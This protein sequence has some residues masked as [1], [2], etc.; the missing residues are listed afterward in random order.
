TWTS[1]VSAIFGGYTSMVIDHNN[2]AILYAAGGNQ[3]KKSTDYGL[4]WTALPGG[5]PTG[6][7][8]ILGMSR[9]SSDSIYV[10]TGYSGEIGLSADAGKT[11]SR[12][13]N[14]L[15]YLGQQAGYAN[16]MAVN[17]SNPSILVAGGLN[18]YSLSRG[19][20][21]L[22][23]STNWQ[24]DPAASNYTHADIHV[25]KYNPYN[26]ELFAL[27]DGGIFYS[28][29]NGAS[30]KQNMNADLGT[31]LFVGGDM[32]VDQTT[33]KPSFFAAGAQDNGLNAFTAG[34]DSYYNSIRG[35]DGGTMF[36]SP[37]G[38]QTIYGTYVYT[39]LYRSDDRGANGDMQNAP[40]LLDGTPI[41]SEGTPFYMVYDV[42]DDDPDVV[43]IC[44][45]RNLFLTQDGGRTYGND[46][47][48]V[49]GS[50]AGNP[51]SGSAVTVD[52]AT[53]ADNDIYLGTTSAV[54][55]SQD[56]GVTWA[57]SL[58]PA[59]F[60]GYYPTS[61]TTDPNDPTHV[62]MTVTG[63]KSKHFWVSTD[64]GQDWTAPATNLPN[65]NYRQ[66]AYD[67]KVIYVGTDYGVLR[68][69]DGGV[70][71]Y[72]VADGFPMTMVTALHVR[73]NYLLAST[74]GRG[75][76]YIDLT[77]VSPVPISSGVVPTAGVTN[78]GAAISAIYPSVV[79][80][81]AARSTIDYTIA[82]DDQATVAVYDILGR[83]ERML[84][85][86]FDTKGDHQVSADLSGLAP[87]Q[88]YVVLT[89]GG[90]SVTKPIT[91]E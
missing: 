10:S 52:I 80:S 39:T 90:V 32:A 45:N 85:N 87:G 70:T 71:W 30:W 28:T 7:L 12:P 82:N 17:P 36:V 68:S 75:M 31:L 1:P 15:N 61:I 22:T 37:S 73:G 14:S 84:V 16:A 20:T 65:L 11:W 55:Y 26:N 49:T 59:S 74:Y 42:A 76:F 6:P 54:Y 79:S 56:E 21:H 91:V 40:N 23:D 3:I 44:G 81:A 2:P 72:P 35:G 58:S 60:S 66:V 43:A 88:H 62:F 78:P 77:Q 69:G 38:G 41:Q 67:G 18:I 46:F 57:K 25:L 63:T 19:A 89:S 33:G 48:P 51:I 29:T 64:G 53:N 50:A 8:M 13:W 9:A 4:T 27:T 24:A 5:Y 86:Q 47:L 83:Q 34:Q